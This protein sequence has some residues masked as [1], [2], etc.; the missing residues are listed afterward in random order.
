MAPASSTGEAPDAI[1]LGG[2]SKR[3]RRLKHRRRKASTSPLK[4]ED[5]K[6]GVNKKP[7]P[8]DQKEGVNKSPTAEDQKEGVNKK[9]WQDQE[10]G[11]FWKSWQTCY[12]ENKQG[13][14]YLWKLQKIEQMGCTVQ[15]TWTWQPAYS[16]PQTWQPTYSVAASVLRGPLKPEDQEE[17]VY[18]K[19]WQTCYIENKQG[20]TYLWKLQKIEQKGCTEQETW[21][22]QP[23]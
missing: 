12:I 19:S 2:G 13:T 4:A 6:E 10:E 9:S 1:V 21:T 14:P 20:K 23:V 16:D 18:K 5:Q 11:V 7:K 17:G 22:W 3:P 8:E 15:E